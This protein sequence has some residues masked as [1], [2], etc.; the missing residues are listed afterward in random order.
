MVQFKNFNDL[1]KDKEYGYYNFVGKWKVFCG[2]S[3]FLVI[4]SFALFFTKGF[5]YGIDFSGG[6]EIQV[7]FDQP[8]EVSAI[9]S[10]VENEG[11]RTA[12]VQS[13]G[14]EN[15]FLIRTET[16]QTSDVDEVNK[17]AEDSIKALTVGIQ[18]S[19]KEQGPDIRRV[20]SVGPQVGEELKKN[21]LLSVFYSLMLILI[22]IALRFDYK[23]APA[24]VIGL[25]HDAIIS[26]GIL[27]LLGK[28]INI[29]TLAAILTVIG[30]SL[31]D[32]IINFDRVRENIPIFKGKHIALVINRSVNDVI[33]RTIL[34]SMTTLIAISALY[35]IAGGVISD[36]AFTLGLG[37][38]IGTYSTVFV[39]AP[40][41]IFADQLQTKL[42]KAGA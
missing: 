9:R 24:A 40:L 36:L 29:H 8:V 27:A 38:I 1:K 25:F 7:K 23:Y 31:N 42:E 33:S 6:T 11:Y 12:S 19:F 5:N 17:A 20:D 18:E 30:Y 3:V 16:L 26:M 21:G 14:D 37:V 10:F 22:Y 13:F 34:T 15:E 41:V 2:L 35:F 4:A 39:V 32:T 28:E